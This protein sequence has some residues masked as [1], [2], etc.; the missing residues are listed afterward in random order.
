M[1]AHYAVTRFESFL[2]SFLIIYVAYTLH[3]TGILDLQK[4]VIPTLCVRLS[5]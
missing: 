3:L 4:E 5:V 2:I 1:L